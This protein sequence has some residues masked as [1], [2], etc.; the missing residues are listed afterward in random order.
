MKSKDLLTNRGILRNM[1]TK[2]PIEFRFWCPAGKS[3]IENYNY[4]GP[5]NELFDEKDYDVLIPQQFTGLLDE[6]GVKIFEGDIVLFQ[7][8]VGDFA[9]EEM[10][11]DEKQ[12]EDQL[13]NKWYL[14]TVVQ[15]LLVPVNMNLVAPSPLGQM[16]FP[17]SYASGGSVVGHTYDGKD[18]MDRLKDEAYRLKMV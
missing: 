2:R 17:L 12:A 18:I 16:Y 9:W 1:N 6:N 10:D 7:Y 11:E 3:F 5:V 14:G 15:D 4:S 13:N 8:R